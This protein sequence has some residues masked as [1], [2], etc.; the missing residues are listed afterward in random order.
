MMR[1]IR[2]RAWSEDTREMIQ[3]ARLDIKEEL[4][5]VPEIYKPY[6]KPVEEE[7]E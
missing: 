2:F 1:E 7:E 6:A 3:V 5:R 4:E